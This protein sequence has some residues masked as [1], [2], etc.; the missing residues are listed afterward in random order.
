MDRLIPHI[1]QVIQAEI[2]RASREQSIV[3]ERR[4]IAISDQKGLLRL[5]IKRVLTN[6]V[7][8]VDDREQRR[9]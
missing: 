4:Q 6:E 1:E 3:A 5:D 9:R 8:V 7:E 2:A